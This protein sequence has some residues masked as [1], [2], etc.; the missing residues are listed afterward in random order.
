MNNIRAIAKA[1]DGANIRNDSAAD[2]ETREQLR[3]DIGWHVSDM[4]N[5]GR[6][7]E[8]DVN[9]AVAILVERFKA[10]DGPWSDTDI[11][12]LGILGRI[13]TMARLDD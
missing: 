8:N 7:I 4:H 2:D 11:E 12:L 1:I 10:T 6:A 13:R 9:E 3:D 5:A